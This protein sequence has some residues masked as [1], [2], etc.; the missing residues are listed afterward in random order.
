MYVDILHNHLDILG[1][2]PCCFY[3]SEITRLR[4]ES[5][6]RKNVSDWCHNIEKFVHCIS[7][8]NCHL[9]ETLSFILVSQ[10]WF[11]LKE[12]TYPIENRD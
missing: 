5:Y 10:K 1:Y 9:E 6:A 2:F 7:C 11:I 12:L 3:D 4:T 8:M